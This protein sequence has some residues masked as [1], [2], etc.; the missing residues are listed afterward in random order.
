MRDS[1]QIC[2]IRLKWNAYRLHYII[3]LCNVTHFFTDISL[4]KLVDSPEIYRQN[5]LY[6]YNTICQ[7][8]K[9][10]F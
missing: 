1:I 8:Y 6:V 10:T 2:N 3:S 9:Y 4:C 5:L 7:N